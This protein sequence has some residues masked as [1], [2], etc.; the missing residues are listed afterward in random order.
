MADAPVLSAVVTTVEAATTLPAVQVPGGD[1]MAILGSGLGGATLFDVEQPQG[2]GLIGAAT[3]ALVLAPGFALATAPPA[4]DGGPGE[5]ALTARNA[6]GD[7]N[8]I[9]VEYVEAGVPSILD[10][11]NAADGSHEAPIVG[12]S[13]LAVFG[14]GFFAPLTVRL[15]ACDAASPTSETTVTLDPANVTILDA[16]LLGVSLPDA[17]FCEGALTLEV[18]TAA[19]TAL[20]DETAA[21]PFLLVGPRAPSVEAAFPNKFFS[22]GGEEAVF[23]GRF[24]TS[25][26]A[27]RVGTEGMSPADFR[28]VLA[29]RIV[30][31]SV[32]IVTMPALPGGVP[33]AGIAGFVVAEESDPTRAAAIDGDPFTLSG[34]LFRVCREGLGVLLAVFP[35]HGF[36]EG[37][38]SVLLIGSGFLNA[39][40][41]PNVTDI[42]FVDPVLGDVGDYVAAS[43]AD[44]PLDASDK[45][46]YFVLNDQQILL[47]TN[48]RTPIPDDLPAPAD[49]IVESPLGSTVLEGGFTY[50][51]S[52][53]VRTPILFAIVPNET[54]LNGGSTHLLTGGFLTEADRILLIRPTDGATFTLDV[55]AEE[56]SEVNDSFLVFTMPDLRGTFEE[57]DL[58]DIRAEKVL[59]DTTVRVSNTLHAA[60]KVTFAGPPTID[61]ALSPSS[62]TAF[63]GTVVE[64]TGDFFTTNSQVLFG[65]MPARNVVFVSP[66]ML[67]AITPTLPVDVPDP[68][69]DLRNIH[70]VSGTVDV[71]VFTQGGWAVM[72]DAFTFGPEAPLLSGCSPDTFAEGATA[73]ITMIGDRFVPGSTTVLAEL[74]TVTNVVVESFTTLRFDYTA[75]TF[76]RGTL[77][78][79]FDHITVSTNQ[80]VAVGTCEFVIKVNPFVDDCTSSFSL[81][82]HASPTTGVDGTSF[83]VVTVEGGNFEPGGTLTLRARTGE[84]I[85]LEEI[86]AD[87]SF[88]A[89]GQFRVL[90][91]TTIEF[92]PPNRFP[93]N[94]PTLID[95]NPNV[96]PVDITYTSLEGRSET[97]A[98][99]FFYV[100]SVLDFDDFTFGVPNTANDVS[101]PDRITAGDI[102]ADGMPDIVALARQTSPSSD[103]SNAEAYV[104]LANTF[105]PLDVNR[106]GLKPDFA[107]SFTRFVISNDAVQTWLEKDGRG[108]RPLLV[109]LDADAQLEI[110]IPVLGG[111]LI[112]DV[113]ASGTLGTQTLL[114]PAALGSSA[115]ISG[116]AAGDFNG[117]G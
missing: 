97:L 112:Q 96:G 89:P 116:I 18:E 33:P 93:S 69:I 57:N 37:G 106:D 35:D 95:G 86:A 107:G 4:P 78:P 5:A 88:A 19:G 87:A 42:R 41:F 15:T 40:G 98:D 17:V 109:N 51:N 49:V 16:H 61:T 26:T 10:V 50:F 45:G 47:I 13:R 8:S 21:V 101:F 74:G 23:A 104:F 54:R 46:K 62:G 25:T 77:G 114:D 12:G 92:T 24:F 91:G 56:F 113:T 66:T 80:G 44:L 11:R 34:E 105:G 3:G 28:P 43:P 2:G 63:G 22:P 65:T 115:R 110:V 75:P 60:I 76:P 99:C 14:E 64:I 71:A 100:A 72:E 55:G 7:S 36:V 94:A 1:P 32:A 83:V 20:F 103:A 67:L 111:V 53:A 9:A 102:N 6:L 27:F 59:P 52:P 29:T 117:D 85:P 84:P 30:S 38:E 68:G 73:R 70:E 31:D 90:N 39:V 79:K 108:A 48:P 81:N 82:E 58:L